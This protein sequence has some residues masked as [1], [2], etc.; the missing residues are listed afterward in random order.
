M[1][2][3][4]DGAAAGSLIFEAG[5]VAVVFCVIS[6][7]VS[8]G[9]AAI[10]DAK[11]GAHAQFKARVR[12]T[13]FSA[14]T[15]SVLSEPVLFG[16]RRLFNA[17]L[18]REKEPWGSF[19]R[20]YDLATVVCYGITHIPNRIMVRIVKLCT[21]VKVPAEQIAENAV[22]NSEVLAKADFFTVGGYIENQIKWN[23]VRFGSSTMA[24]SGC[25]IMAVYN[26]LHAMGKEMTVQD[27]VELI[28]TFERKGAVMRGKWGCSPYAVYNYFLKCGYQTFFTC[29][30]DMHHINEIAE[31]CETVIAMAYNNRYDIRSMIHT[32]SVTR[33]ENGY[34]ILHNA[35]KRNSAGEY[36]A[37]VGDGK[38]ESLRKAVK[39][40]SY[41]GQAS[42]ICVIGIG[43]MHE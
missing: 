32:I 3:L 21:V 18:H 40:M 23:S 39:H 1:A 27:M 9:S 12:R 4:T 15:F 42:A 36:A 37:Y 8:A 19:W 13:V 30:K 24:Y 16:L 34:Y 6:G 29:S 28:S 33:D 43:Q 14:L 5:I 2:I 26:A 11:E 10:H 20:R 7:A 31:S 38:I 35:Y 22:I 41:N 17:L 25:E